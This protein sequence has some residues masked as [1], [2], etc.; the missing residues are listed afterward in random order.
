[1]NA[2][3]YYA[4]IEG[5]GNQY[6]PNYASLGS[7]SLQASFIDHDV[8]LPLRQL[9]LAGKLNNSRHE[10]SW[11]IDADEKVINQTIESST[12]G[13]DFSV[14]T[15]PSAEVRSYSYTPSASGLLLYR[16]VVT[17]DNGKQYFSNT[18]SLLESSS[19]DSKPRLNGNIISDRYLSVNSPGNYAF[20]VLDL[21]GKAIAKGQITN[22]INSV[23]TTI[24]AAGMYFINFTNGK[25]QWTEKFVKQ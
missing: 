16:L 10:L 24:I 9:E 6:A 2:G 13:R 5:R 21:S 8:P 12:N 14:L 20:H 23:N 25:E 19:T 3:V 11:L 17:F 1:L 18:I 4:K 7:Y 15:M 22:G